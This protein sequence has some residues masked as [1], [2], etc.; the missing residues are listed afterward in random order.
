MPTPTTMSAASDAGEIN[1]HAQQKEQ[2]RASDYEDTDIDS[3]YGDSVASSTAS[4][5]ASVLEDCKING[6]TYHCK[7]S[8]GQSWNPNDEKHCEAL[9]ILHGVSILMQDGKLYLADLGDN[10]RVRWLKVLDVGCGTA[11]SDFADSH[12]LAEVIGID[13]SARQLPDSDLPL[14]VRFDVDDI[15]EAWTYPPNTFHYVHV[16]WLTG[17]IED[18]IALY[19]EIFKALKPG[20]TFE[21]KESS[22]MIR[23]DNGTRDPQSALAKWGKMFISAGQKSGRTFAVVEDDIQREAMEAAGF[24]DIRVVNFKVPI[25]SWSADEK[26]KSIGAAV[27]R[28][29]QADPEGFI[30]RPWGE[31]LGWEEDKMMV[32]AA[33]L[34]NELKAGKSHAWCSMKVV[35]GKKPYTD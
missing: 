35:I 33:Y 28:A 11:R 18:W 6:R 26:G 12:P 23:I 7:R 3:A 31:S 5:S 25:G 27:D 14:N 2:G 16:R 13:I 24:I 15:T 29:L 1:L 9:D 17:S 34:R 30:N 19:K 32:Y 4:L 22:C 21:H 10:H 20:G 8:R